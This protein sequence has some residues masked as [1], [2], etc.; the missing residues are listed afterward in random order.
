VI[1]RA[2]AVAV[3][4]AVAAAAVLPATAPATPGQLVAAGIPYAF[5]PRTASLLV[6]DDGRDDLGPSRPPDELN[7]VRDVTRTAPDFGFPA[8]SD[9]GGPACRSTTAPWWRCPPTPHPAAWRSRRI[10]AGAASRRSWPRTA[11]SHPA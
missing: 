6:T 2:L 5:I 3:V 10:G 9:L 7:L 11:R 8:C 4:L 1:R